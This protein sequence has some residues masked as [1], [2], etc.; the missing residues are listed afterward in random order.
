MDKTSERRRTTNV[1]D[2][3]FVLCITLLRGRSPVSTN[4]QTARDD[5]GI[6][7]ILVGRKRTNGLRA[8][9]G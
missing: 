3:G 8:D 4:P 6:I 5:V 1:D 2:V 7:A 9:R